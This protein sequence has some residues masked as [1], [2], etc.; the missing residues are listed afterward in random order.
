MGSNKERITIRTNPEEKKGWSKN[1]EAE[2]RT[3]TNFIRNAVIEHIGNMENH[4]SERKILDLFIDRNAL[5]EFKKLVF[6]E[7]AYEDLKQR[8]SKWK[9][10]HV[11][12]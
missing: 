11:E 12:D 2:R 4:D 6:D 9:K 3:L 10:K 1:A 5:P 7:K 8:V